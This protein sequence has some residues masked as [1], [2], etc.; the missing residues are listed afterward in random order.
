L[1]QK[2]TFVDGRRLIVP[3]G[4][5][6][7]ECTEDAVYLAATVRNV[8]AGIAVLHGWHLHPER[9]T[10]EDHPTPEESTRL[11]RDLYVA[12]GDVGFWQGAF[13][14]PLAPAFAEAR[15]AIQ[16]HGDST[17]D[18]L[19]GD[20]EGGQRMVS[21]YTMVPRDDG[22]WLAAMA[23]HWNLDRDEPR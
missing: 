23:R 11:T 1:A 14:D 7:A 3:G 12:V 18:V 16:A 20:A 19:Y 4:S 8:G 10:S 6:V 13:R 15:A 22:Q 17:I 5:G 9:V 2:I 21:R